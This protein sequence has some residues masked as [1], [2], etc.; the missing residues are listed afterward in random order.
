MQSGEIRGHAQPPI[1]SVSED[2]IILTSCNQRCRSKMIVKC[3]PYSWTSKRMKGWIA[4][5]FSFAV[6]FYHCRID[7]QRPSS[8]FWNLVRSPRTTA[9]VTMVSN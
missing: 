9:S 6:I 3:A 5:T 1:E 2:L 8:D 4:G 7:S